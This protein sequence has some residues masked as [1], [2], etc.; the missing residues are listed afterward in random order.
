M[1]NWFTEGGK[2]YAHYRPHY[3]V[4]LSHYLSTLTPH[5]ECAIDVGCGSGQLTQL[6]SSH[7]QSV[8]GMDPS[9][10]Q[11][12]H[13][14]KH[15]SIQYQTA[16]AEQL[17]LK[18]H[19]AD[20]LTAA[21]AAHWFN[22]DLFYSEVKRVL[23]PSGV[24]ALISYG[25]LRIDSADINELFQQFY[26]E[27]IATF[28]PPERRLVD[29]GYKTLPFPFTEV[30]TPIL[31]IELEWNLMELVG[32]ISTWSATKRILAENKDHLLNDF[33]TSLQHY[34]PEQEAKLS[35]SWPINL[36]VGKLV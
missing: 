16:S 7:F 10:D 20:L 21:Q 33:F 5:H 30:T 29:E 9:F 8:L 25:V 1:L 34:W 36:R 22:L 6:L 27:D 31:H 12:Q 23:K 15:P 2:N 35:V 13:A 24:L 17:P 26:Y 32:Y 19:C 28:W 14:I 3:P 18:H 11:L 4:A